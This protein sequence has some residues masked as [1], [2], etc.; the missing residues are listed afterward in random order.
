ML[1]VSIFLLFLAVCAYGDPSP[2]VS[3]WTCG[4]KLF[5]DYAELQFI[6]NL[7][8]GT[9]YGVNRN[10]FNC[11]K[12]LIYNYSSDSFA[13][14]A[15]FT[16]YYWD[17]YFY[18]EDEQMAS[19]S[20]KFN[21]Y[22]VYNINVTSIFDDAD[23]QID[24]ISSCSNENRSFYVWLLILISFS[25]FS[26][27][28]LTFQRELIDDVM[29]WTGF[30]SELSLSPSTKTTANEA[31][32]P[33]NTSLFPH[34]WYKVGRLSSIDTFRGICLS[35][36]IF[37]NYGGGGYV[38]L[39]HAPWNGL[40][41][42]DLLFPWFMWTMGCSMALSMASVHDGPAGASNVII[43]ILHHL[44]SSRFRSHADGLVPCRPPKRDSLLSGPVHQQ[45]R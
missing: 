4:D 43:L 45:R 30:E 19:K 39:N 41:V 16:P 7:P 6:N 18:A 14:I 31:N 9:L 15:I 36:M 40:T 34:R 1:L 3:D 5:R 33:I 17:L 32:R 21:G 27:Y 38:F 24:T 28:I 20:F 25:V 42:A 22:E 12:E 35:L 10:C 44:I 26:Y 11:A 23:I 37:V 29:M 8:T 13:C 2:I